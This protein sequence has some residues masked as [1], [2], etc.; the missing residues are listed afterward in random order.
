MLLQGRSPAV[1]MAEDSLENVVACE[2]GKQY[3]QRHNVLCE[4]IPD[5]TRVLAPWTDQEEGAQICCGNFL[6]YD[7]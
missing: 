2:K 7:E 4:R 6:T 5:A 3:L 1:Y